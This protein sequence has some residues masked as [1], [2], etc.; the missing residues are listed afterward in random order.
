MFGDNQVI[1]PR[2]GVWNMVGKKFVEA[3]Q[4]LYFGVINIT[5]RVERENVELFISDLAVSGRKM[6][7]TPSE[8]IILTEFSL[9]IELS[10]IGMEI[11]KSLFISDIKENDL[12]KE[13]KKRKDEYPKLQIIFVIIHQKGDPAYGKTFLQYDFSL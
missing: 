2:D 1:T 8:F 13:M 6:G 3:R 10:F 11:G 12:E 4:L 9:G 5:K 7:K